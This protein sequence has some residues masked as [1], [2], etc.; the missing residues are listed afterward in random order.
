[1]ESQNVG[2]MRNTPT[3]YVN[4]FQIL[5]SI[6]EEQIKINKKLENIEKILKDNHLPIKNETKIKFKNLHD[7]CLGC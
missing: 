1:M 6:K 7:L 3:K 4:Y 5:Y 2:D